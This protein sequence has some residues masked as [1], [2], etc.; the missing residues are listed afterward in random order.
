MSN[1]DTILD[2]W[3]YAKKQKDK[4]EKECETYKGA[5][6]RYMDRKNTNKING[7]HF[8]VSRRSNTR[9]Q[10]SK[11]NVPPEVWEKYTNRIT[12]NS[13]YLNKK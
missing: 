2:K 10:L 11:Q 3:Y 12:Y 4:Y 13:Y 5:V 9:Q 6:Q 7:N 1:I 8:T